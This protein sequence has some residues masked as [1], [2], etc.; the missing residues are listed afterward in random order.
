MFTA[1]GSAHLLADFTVWDND[2]LYALITIVSIVFAAV[3]IIAVMRQSHSPEHAQLE[4]DHMKAAM[5]RLR[6]QR[7]Q[8]KQGMI[9]TT[10]TASTDTV[11]P[12]LGA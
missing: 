9:D 4:K 3:L 8:S 12:P 6:E 5:Q 7:Q 10:T 2:G 1:V 11:T